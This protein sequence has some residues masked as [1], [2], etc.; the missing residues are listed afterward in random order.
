[1]KLTLLS[2]AYCHLCDE[3]LA[4][5]QPIAR[6]HGA[7]VEVIDVD[8]PANAALEA[9]WGDR[10]PALFAGEPG[11]GTLLCQYHLDVQCVAK[12]LSAPIAGRVADGNPL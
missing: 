6:A 1:L 2:R 5:V 12:A 9:L 4:S 11:T 7:T 8:A 3:M 10:V